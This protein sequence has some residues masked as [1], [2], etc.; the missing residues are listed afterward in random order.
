MTHTVQELLNNKPEEELNRLAHL[1]CTE[2]DR[3]ADHEIVALVRLNKVTVVETIRINTQLANLS[4]AVEGLH[5][6]MVQTTQKLEQLVKNK[7]GEK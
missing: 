1:L 4:T 3:V 7:R 6:D 2:P 5:T